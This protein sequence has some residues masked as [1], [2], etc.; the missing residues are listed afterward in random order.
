M[1]FRLNL[2]GAKF[3]VV[4]KMQQQI[5]AV[6][7]DKVKRVWFGG[8]RFGLFERIQKFAAAVFVGDNLNVIS[9]VAKRLSVQVCDRP[10]LAQ[11]TDAHAQGSV[12]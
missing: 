7:D 11:G 2:C 12:A 10:H 8:V 5:A 3:A 6:V 9:H 4:R 1:A